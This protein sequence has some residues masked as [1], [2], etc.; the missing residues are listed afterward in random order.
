ML[1]TIP[2]ATSKAV[3]R[4]RRGHRQQARRGSCRNG[5]CRGAADTKAT[6]RVGRSAPDVRP[7]VS[8]RN[9]ES[10]ASY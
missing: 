1:G 8:N 3:S 10:S 6:G 7:S 2:P 9:M 5:P 4:R